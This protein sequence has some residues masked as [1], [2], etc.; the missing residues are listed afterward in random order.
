MKNFLSDSISTPLNPIIL[1]IIFIFIGMIPALML[2]NGINYFLT[3]I[4]LGT[5]FAVVQC[6]IIQ[7]K[8]QK[9]NIRIQL[10]DKRYAVFQT[11]IDSITIIKRNNWDRYMLLQNVDVNNQIISIEEE[12]YKCVHLSTY[13]FDSDFSDKL[14]KINNGYCAVVQAYKNLLVFSMSTFTEAEAIAFKNLL[15]SH[16]LL[17]DGLNSQLYQDELKEMFPKTYISLLEFSN[18][19]NSYLEIIGQTGILKEFPKYINVDGLDK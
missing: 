6:A 4:S 9:D 8:I 2:D 13:L 5:S 12:L 1:I 10:F 11:I 7:N 16:M 3:C 14:L 15:S 17:P 19:C 18:V